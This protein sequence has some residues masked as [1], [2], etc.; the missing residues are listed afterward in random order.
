MSVVDK[1]EPQFEERRKVSRQSVLLKSRVSVSNF[2]FDTVVYDLS[3]Y[4]AKIKLDLPLDKGTLLMIQI[5][6]SAYIPARIAWSKDKFI[7]LEFRRPP[8]K[9][10]TILGSLGDHLSLA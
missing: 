6:S 8:T 9:M 4:G 7:G 5:R 1:T 10:K 2:H 3:L